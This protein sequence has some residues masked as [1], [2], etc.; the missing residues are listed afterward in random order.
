MNLRVI[1][2]DTGETVPWG[3]E[4]DF[5]VFLIGVAWKSWERG[6]ILVSHYGSPVTQ[7]EPAENYGLQV[8]GD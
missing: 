1:N 3:A 2:K 7:L 6:E 5:G 8:A 4:I